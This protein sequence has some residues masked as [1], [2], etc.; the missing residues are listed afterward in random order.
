MPDNQIR[1]LCERRKKSVKS[2][3]VRLDRTAFEE[4]R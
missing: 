3:A 4:L 1:I 2:S